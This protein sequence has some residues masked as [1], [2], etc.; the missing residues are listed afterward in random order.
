[1]EILQLSGGHRSSTGNRITLA[2]QRDDRAVLVGKTSN[3]R[4][5]Y[6]D[7]LEVGAKWAYFDPLGA[8][9]SKSAGLSPTIF[10]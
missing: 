8:E 7:G 6:G 2:G 1:M 5:V 3:R 4:R 10:P 9:G